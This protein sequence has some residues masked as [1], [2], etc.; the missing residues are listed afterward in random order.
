MT[1][2]RKKPPSKVAPE[3]AGRQDPVPLSPVTPKIGETAG[4]LQ[5]RADAFKRRHG[6][7]G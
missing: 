4:N 3:P 5:G 1:T 2:S 6:K 7:T